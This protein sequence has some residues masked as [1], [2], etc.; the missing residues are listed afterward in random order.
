L[1]VDADPAGQLSAT[2][3]QGDEDARA[4]AGAHGDSDVKPVVQ[5]SVQTRRLAL[6]LGVVVLI[7]AGSL[8]AW[9][10]YRAYQTRQHQH[11]RDLFLQV[12]RQAA[13]NLTT[14]SAAEA[15]A[16]VARVLDTT[17]GKFHDDWAQRAP[18]FVDVVKKAQSKTEGSVTSAA[19][20]SEASDRARVLVTVSVKTSS[21]GAPE[22]RPRAW[23]M[24]VDVQKVGDGAKVANVEF[25]P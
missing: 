25:V 15:E 20:E 12:G 3:N 19:L 16:D 10:G 24:R 6:V 21:A 17:T 18:A 23:R 22:E 1:A 9:L 2:A 14:I 7:A 8:F 11:Q 5:Q 4:E 13:L